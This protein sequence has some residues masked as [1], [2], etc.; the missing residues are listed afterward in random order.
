MKCED[1]MN[2]HVECLDER[3]TIEK[4]AVV[5]AES[6]IG[7]LPICDAKQRVIGVITDRD[8]TV[9]AVAKKVS[10]ATTSA[11]LIMTAPP[12]TCLASSDLHDAEQLMRE[13][14]KSRLV[15]VDGAGRACGVLSLA[16]LFEFAPAADALKTAK[17]LL[18]REALG[19]HGGAAHGQPL[20]KD[21][22]NVRDLPAPDEHAHVKEHPVFTGG[23]R[24][25]G[26]KEFPD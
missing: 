20:L 25:G 4:A 18:W 14:L 7:F 26:L 24:G 12:V 16:D 9:R 3:D 11:A 23:H 2:K 19:P 17:A 13:E 22:P 6:G 5:M 1:I 10:P 21:D 8:I 15:I